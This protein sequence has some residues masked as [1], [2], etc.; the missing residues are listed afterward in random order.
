MSSQSA[1]TPAFDQQ[2]RRGRPAVL[3]VFGGLDYWSSSESVAEKLHVARNRQIL[4]Q[5]AVIVPSGRLIE[6]RP[7][8]IGAEAQLVRAPGMHR[9]KYVFESH[10]SRSACW[11][12]SRSNCRARRVGRISKVWFPCGLD[13]RNS[14]LAR[15]TDLRQRPVRKVHLILDRGEVKILPPVYGGLEPG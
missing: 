14:R 9:R 15:E 8:D 3:D 1:R 10:C 13:C 12:S 5:H 7:L 2:A 6:S 4:A 11:V